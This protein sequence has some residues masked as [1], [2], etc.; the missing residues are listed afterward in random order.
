MLTTSAHSVPSGADRSGQPAWRRLVAV[1]LIALLSPV[2]ALLAFWA[3]ADSDGARDTWVDPSS[4]A[5]FTLS[6]LDSFSW[7]IDGDGLAN[8]QE[9]ALGTDPF[10][11]DTDG[12]GLWDAFDP[13]PLDSSNSSQANG[14]VWGAFAMDDADGDGIPNFT[15]ADPYGTGGPAVDPDGDG[16]GIP[17][18]ID[19]APGD[20]YNI[21]PANGL[22]WMGDAL[23]DADA[24]GVVN[25]HDWYPYDASRWDAVTDGDQDGISDGSDPNPNDYSNYSFAN[26]ISWGADAFGDSDADGVTNFYDAYPYDSG[27]GYVPSEPDADGDGIPDSSDPSPWDYDNFSAANGVSWQGD[28]RGDA[29]ND[30]ISNFYD[31]FPYDYYNGN[32]PVFDQDGDGI[33]DAEDPAPTDPTNLSPINGGLWHTAALA[34]AD[35]DGNPSFTDPWPYDPTNGNLP[36]E[37]NSPTA[38]TDADGIPNAQDPAL[39]D[40][41]NFSIYNGTSWY[42]DAVGDIDGDGIVNFQDSYPYDYYNGSYAGPDSDGDGMTDSSDPYPNDPNNGNGDADGDGIVDSQDPYPYDPTNGSG[43]TGGGGDPQPEPESD[44]DND[45]IPDSSDPAQGDSAN[46]SPINGYSWYGDVRGDAD[47]DG[48]QNFW[49]LEPYGPPPVDTDADGL[50]DSVDPAPEDPRNLSPH[51]GREWLSDALGDYDG[52]GV[53]NFFDGWPD[54]SMNG[55]VDSDGDGVPDGTDPSQWDSANLSPFNGVSWGASALGDDDADGIP[56]YFDEW[57]QDRFNGADA[58]MDGIPDPSDPAPGDSMN[59]SPHNGR[60]WYGSEVLGDADNDGILNFFDPYPEDFYNGNPPVTDGGGGGNDGGG[61][62]SGDGSGGGSGGSGGAGET[63][64]TLSPYNNLEWGDDAW[65]DADSDGWLNF[66]DR[67]PFD[68]Y[69]RP[70]DWVNLPSA[71]ASPLVILNDGYDE[72]GEPAAPGDT[73]KRDLEDEELAIKAGDDAGKMATMGLTPFHLSLPP[74]YLAEGGSV[75]I[76]KTEG[77]GSVLVHAVRIKD[78]IPE[79]HVVPFGSSY[80]PPMGDDWTYWIEGVTEGDVAL[81]CHFPQRTYGSDSLKPKGV[82]EQDVDVPVELKVRSANLAVDRDR[83]GVISPGSYQDAAFDGRPFRFWVNDDE[84]FGEAGD[85][86]ERDL[87]GAYATI[88][89][90]DPYT[91]QGGSRT[92]LRANSQLTDHVDGSR[93]LVDFFPVSL[94]IQ[95]VLAVFPPDTNTKYKLKHAEGALNFT[96][97]D[98][99][100]GKVNDYLK[101]VLGSGFGLDS[102][103]AARAATTWQI[104]AEG[105]EVSPEFLKK[106]G[107]SAG[108]VILVECRAQTDKPLVLV[109]EKDGVVVAEL[110]AALKVGA[111][112]Q[113]YRHVDLTGLAKEYDG[114]SITPPQPP[115]PTNMGEPSGLPDSEMN[116]KYF[117]FVHGFN[118]D[119]QNARGWNAEVFKRLYS[120]GSRAR[121]VGVTWNGTPPSLLQGEY[122]DYHKAVFQA[123]QAGDGLAGALGLNSA[124]VTIAAHSLGNMVVSHAIQ[125]GGFQA[126]NYFMINAAVP[127]EAYVP[128]VSDQKGAGTAYERMTE[129]GWKGKDD[130]MFASNWHRLFDKA[131]DNRAR[132]TWKGVFKD[133]RRET[134]VTNFYSPGEDVVEN[135]ESSSSYIVWDTFWDSNKGAWGHQEMI[136]GGEVL[137]TLPFSRLQGGWGFEHY[138]TTENLIKLYPELTVVILQKT[139]LFNPFLEQGLFGEN[140]SQVA[141]EPKVRYDVLA[142]GIPAMSYAVAPNPLDGIESFD[143]EDK[144]SIAGKWPTDG[145]DSD[146]RGRWLHSDFK[147]VAL[148]YVQPMFQEMIARGGLNSK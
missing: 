75:T 143:M 121:F 126:K 54:D 21:S 137:G 87:D 66:Y 23:A 80:V 112:E 114:G 70:P 82:M 92:A 41:L 131:T 108:G 140:G 46:S 139:P 36:P 12:D 89:T 39:A 29:D 100:K 9:L 40:P 84:D 31:Q 51:N 63:P 27:N 96:Y 15:D 52:D 33:P 11:A 76:S 56:N 141:A 144:G 91:G 61:S 59:Y 22:P 38:D 88:N 35:G 71:S 24:D 90:Y 115:K 44:F 93:D 53:P 7:D 5:V 98:L 83:D 49:D 47:C 127:M 8:A 146:R 32:V 94:D 26:G 129:D 145:H 85:S 81:K 136:K 125:S 107:F 120:L 16:D 147:N 72:L 128:T 124:D 14:I 111:V 101:K 18:L 62:G 64:K 69:Q 99:T 106:E 148:P 68:G 10:V 1:V 134:S 103:Q 132:L 6:E 104:T 110:S 118:I 28:A 65:D 2:P 30:G 130:R 20:P 57:P 45:G 43:G 60:N 78:N 116:D 74:D 34:D 102:S 135:P 17:D 4:G 119:G 55:V 3:D 19:P 48:V 142:R 133:V 37:W 42:A 67:N 86:G 123:F 13:L 113:M 25:F 117:V 50:I 77:E 109:V 73:P 58:D 97:S 138:R 105:V 122:L 79:E 95:Q